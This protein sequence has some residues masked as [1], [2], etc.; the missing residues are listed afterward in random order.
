MEESAA[1]PDGTWAVYSV[2]TEPNNSVLVRVDLATGRIDTLDTGCIY[3]QTPAVS[4]DGRLISATGLCRGRDQ[5]SYGLYTLRPDGPGLREIVPGGVASAP[6]AWSPD[7]L[8]LVYERRTNNPPEET[9]AI[10][11]VDGSGE[12]MLGPGFS[13]AWSPDGQWI[14][15]AG[16]SR[17]G[18]DRTLSVMRPDGADRRVVFVNR[19]TTTYFRGW[20]NTREGLPTGTPVWYPDSRWI[21]FA[22]RYDAGTSIW[23]VDVQSGIVQRVTRPDR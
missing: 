21:A 5:E 18:D 7:G 9:L 16:P 20:G 6:A 8:R 12:R 2:A 1:A 14:A 22:R 3:L 11:G 19:E 10:V 15:F 13:P 17:R 23:R 4:P